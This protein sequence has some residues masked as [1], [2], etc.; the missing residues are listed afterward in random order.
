MREILLHVFFYI[1]NSDRQ[2][3]PATLLV[4]VTFFPP[5]HTVHATF[6][7][8]GAPSNISNCF[9]FKAITTFQYQ[10]CIFNWFEIAGNAAFVQF[11]QHS[12]ACNKV[13][14]LVYGFISRCMDQLVDVIM[15]NP[16]VGIFIIT[17]QS[18]RFEM[19]A[20]Y[21]F[22]LQPFTGYLT[23]H[24]THRCPRYPIIVILDTPTLDVV[25]C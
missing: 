8:H 19:V 17:T 22:K 4:K 11:L 16:Q 15:Q 6:T 20:V 14:V 24:T 25:S 1:F 12:R 3:S 2:I 23:F 13:N 10:F 7:A 18:H 9:I 21:C 5:L